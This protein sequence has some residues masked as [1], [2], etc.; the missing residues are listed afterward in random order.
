MKQHFRIVTVVFLALA[1]SCQML[2][3][4]GNAQPDVQSQSRSL[5]A[6]RMEQLRKQS[7]PARKFLEALPPQH[8][9]ALSGDAQNFLNLVMRAGEIEG[10]LGQGLPNRGLGPSRAGAKTQAPPLS[11]AGDHEQGLIPVNDP[12]TD[13][14][15][16]LLVGFTQSETSTA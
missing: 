1:A 4:A 16:G 3:Q 14:T 10:E 7:E 5:A 9:R 15:F 13:F 6:Q 12:S 11:A 8:R 2:A